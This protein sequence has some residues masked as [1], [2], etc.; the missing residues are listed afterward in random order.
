MTSSDTS[1]GCIFEWFLENTNR[2]AQ[3]KVKSFS[4]CR[5]SNTVAAEEKQRINRRLSPASSFPATSS[6]TLCLP[7]FEKEGLRNSRSMDYAAE[8]Y[9]EALLCLQIKI[10]KYIH[11]STQVS[12]PDRLRLFNYTQYFCL[13]PKCVFLFV[14]PHINFSSSV[15]RLVVLSRLFGW[16]KSEYSATWLQT[17]Q[18]ASHFLLEHIE[19][20]NNKQKQQANHKTL[21]PSLKTI[22]TLQTI[23]SVAAERFELLRT[24]ISNPT[25]A[26]S[27]PLE[28][29][30]RLPTT[31]Q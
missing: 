14:F 18:G 26:L 1:L 5:K 31:Q 21:T 8:C 4:C 29:F 2:Q 13:I 17:K 9:M 27:A 25:L 24:H 7:R 23:R 30:S 6:S 12:T 20:Q 10:R 11:V 22:Q 16:E 15:G 3:I 28:T 19:N